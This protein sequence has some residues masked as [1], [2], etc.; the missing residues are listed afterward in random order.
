MPAEQQLI[1]V[2]AYTQRHRLEGELL[3][4]KGEHLNDKLNLLE[5]QFEP[6]HNAR[7]FSLDT[8]EL[9]HEAPTVA[10]NKNHVTLMVEKHRN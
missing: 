3:L 6:L 8:G 4:L 9:Q 10:L 1:P 7:V 2:T 5:R